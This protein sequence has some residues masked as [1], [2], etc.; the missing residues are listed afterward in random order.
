MASAP[1]APLR[2]PFA[3]TGKFRPFLGL[4]LRANLG[5]GQLRVSVND[6]SISGS[7]FPVGLALGIAAAR[8]L[9]VFGEAYQAH[10][11]RP[12]GDNGTLSALDLYGVGPG[13]KYHFKPMN[14]FLSGSLLISWV[15]YTGIEMTHA[16]LTGR[17][18]AGKEWWIAPSWTL[19]VAGEYLLGHMEGK[20]SGYPV[21]TRDGFT[22]T[23]YSLLVSSS[24][25]FPPGPSDAL[26]GSH[27]SAMDNA[28]NEF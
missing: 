18:S 16:G 4:A 25:V 21:A 15:K 19:G 14:V 3:P 27:A 22:A 13:L 10:V 11:F 24:F 28:H 23:G 9:I 20:S 8:N 5:V 7:A 2:P 17:F 12:R 1:P 6:R 26:S